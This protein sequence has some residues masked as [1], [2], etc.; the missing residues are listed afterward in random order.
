L[1]LLGNKKAE[2][3]AWVESLEA[4][5]MVKKKRYDLVTSENYKLQL[6]LLVAC[7]KCQSL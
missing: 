2:L 1:K 3:D 7:L 5:A 4:D 6:E